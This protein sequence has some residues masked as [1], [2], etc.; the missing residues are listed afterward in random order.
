MK[1]MAVSQIGIL[2]EEDGPGIAEKSP[3]AGPP[4]LAVGRV[5]DGYGID[6]E[7]PEARALG[8]EPGRHGRID[9]WVGRGVLLRVKGPRRGRARPDQEGL[10]CTDCREV[11][12]EVTG[13]EGGGRIEGYPEASCRAEGEG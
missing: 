2:E 5:S 1:E 3:V 6:P 12:L 8:A 13:E 9:P 11:G 10:D 4:L 7:E